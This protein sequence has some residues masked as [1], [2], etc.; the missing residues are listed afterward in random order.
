MAEKILSGLFLQKSGEEETKVIRLATKEDEQVVIRLCSKNAWDGTTIL[1]AY[2]S[3][4]EDVHNADW[5]YCDLWVGE[6][7]AQKKNAQY[8]LCRQGQNFHIV[9]KPHSK[10]RWQELHDFLSM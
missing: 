9:G 1:S 2:Q 5:Q 3:K 6:S 10:Q 4:C 7:G 8:L